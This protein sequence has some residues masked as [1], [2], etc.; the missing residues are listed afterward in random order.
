MLETKN[1]LKTENCFSFY[2]NSSMLQ[3]SRTYLIE[4]FF[5]NYVVITCF[6]SQNCDVKHEN[7]TDEEKPNTDSH[8][9]GH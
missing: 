4:K 9:T 5:E 3:L 2:I 1:N 8:I 6:S 7:V